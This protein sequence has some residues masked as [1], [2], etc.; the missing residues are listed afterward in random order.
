MSRSQ[1]DALVLGLD[2][3]ALAGP[4]GLWAAPS[5]GWDAA[6]LQAAFAAAG[7]GRA[8]RLL[9]APGLCRHFVL[10][11]PAGLRSLAEW[12][13][14][15]ALRAQQLFGGEAWV[16]VADWR[17]GAAVPCAALPAA[18][19]AA[20][21]QAADAAGR[22]L[23]VESAVMLALARLRSRATSS[24][25]LGFA[26]PQHAV[27]AAWQDGAVSALHAARRPAEADAAAIAA[28]LSRS[29]ARESL[30]NADGRMPEVAL[31]WAG[32]GAAPAGALDAAACLPALRAG[33]TEA[34]WA[35]R[36]GALA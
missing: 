13:Q 10:A 25:C 3:E 15:A 1:P 5:S 2:A 16:A 17:A 18:L 11:A 35:Q 14:L 12:R 31:A 19:L 20:C 26:T 29:A 9:V 22:V 33:D 28:Q 21:R 8:L 27:L 23:G 7:E 32:P 36:L 34:A 30:L 24:G 4:S 6:S